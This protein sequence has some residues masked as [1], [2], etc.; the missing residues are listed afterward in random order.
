MTKLSDSAFEIAKSRYFK[1]DETEWSQ[2]AH[3][4]CSENAKNEPDNQEK[5]YKEFMSII[6]PM[7]FIPAG[8]ILRNLGKLRPATSNCNV[9]PIEDNIESILET[10]KYYGIISAYG[11]GNGINFSTL[12]PKGAPLTTR[13]GFSSGMIS[14]IEMF[15]E[16]GKRLET[17]GNRRCLPESSLIFSQEGLVPIKDISIGTKVYTENNISKVTNKFFQG[18]QNI[19]EVIT[20]A[21]I[22]QATENH[23][24]AVLEKTG[25]IGWKRV[26]MLSKD[27]Q[28]V[29]FNDCV[30]GRKTELPKDFTKARPKHSITSKPF[31]VPKLDTDVAWL[32]GL[33]H[34]DGTVYNRYSNKGVGGGSHLSICFHIDNTTAIKKAKKILNDKFEVEVVIKSRSPKEN[35]VD[36][37]V[38]NQRLTEYLEKYIKKPEMCISVPTFILE[39]TSNIRGAYLAGLID[40]DGSIKTRPVNLVTSIYKSFILE[41]STLYNSLGIP[42]RYKLLKTIPKKWKNKHCLNLIGFT[43]TY[44]TLI[45]KYSTKGI[46]PK[47][48]RSK[49]FNVN[50]ELVKLQLRDK[51]YRKK[52]DGVSKSM[53]YETFIECGGSLPGIPINIK[54]IT[55][56]DIKI[57]TYDIEVENDHNFYADGFLVHNSA[58]MAMC[59]V[60]HPEVLDFID[61]KME[62]N[63]LN[64][65]NISV[66]ID[67]YFLKAV[68]RNEDWELK[69]AGKVYNV[70]K[71]R[72]IWDKILDNMLKHAEPGLINWD[73]LK[74]NNSY[75]FA[76]ISAVNPC[77]EQPLE[78]LGTCL[79]GSL[80]LPNFVTNVNT[81]W[82]KL[83]DTIYKAVRFLDNIIDIAFFPIAKQEEVT[84]NARKI[85]MGTMGLADYLFKKQIRY[86]SDRCIQELERLYKFIRDTAYLASVKLAK[87]KGAFPK[88]NR[89]DYMSASFVKKLP[90][91][92]RMEIREN[93]IR[94]SCILSQAP[95]GTTGLIADVVGGIEPL[96]FKGY[97]R[98]DRVGE[99]IYVHPLAKEG[100]KGD[101]FVDSLDLKP[102]EHLEVQ[103]II[104]KYTC[105]GISK[106]I[107][108]P[109][110]TTVKDLDKCLMEYIHDLK[111]VTVYRDGSREE[112]VYYRLTNEEIKKYLKTAD[113]TLTVE[114]V[115]CSTGSCEI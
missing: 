45:G 89:T 68:E 90:A 86:G 63:K 53:N 109:E 48:N 101:W 28:L 104:Q 100:V 80:V 113:S 98:V 41:V 46:L 79:L 7:L 23:K 115:E 1:E 59:S 29:H 66:S 27:D 62:H 10:L 84:K 65:F 30:K 33:I 93:A 47:K 60:Y 82:K 14:F 94:N 12:R 88:Y 19:I 70:V 75:Y 71:A 26:G 37:S 13:G 11:G 44:N 108:L 32:V 4:I 36:M 96:P 74:K 64:Q 57:K 85:G 69:F 25:S 35:C 40:S 55:N 83:E 81:D 38:Y 77:G 99:R 34:G 110:E 112:Q 78:A 105:A 107:I 21:G 24:V 56:T 5:Y 18:E 16:V 114:D 76:P 106:T 22:F 73:N 2:L 15:D 43:D 87:E 17:G 92:I 111:G 67:S 51:Q 52:W 9:L 3:R 95:T 49:G 97:K 39:S 91:K 61:A 102:E 50:N 6:D 72:D 20:N 42:C 8:R 103:S 54:S 31:K 58:G